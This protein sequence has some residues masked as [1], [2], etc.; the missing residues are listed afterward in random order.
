MS[1]TEVR[2]AARVLEL[3]EFLARVGGPPAEALLVPD[4]AIGTDQT[5]K[6][7]FVV[8]DDGTAKQTYVTLGPVFDGNALV[9]E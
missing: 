1:R 5:R 7:V 3:L 2:S 9:W 6:F 8:Q 4:V